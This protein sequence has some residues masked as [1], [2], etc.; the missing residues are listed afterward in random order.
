VAVVAASSRLESLAAAIAAERQHVIPADIDT[1]SHDSAGFIAKLNLGDPAGNDRNAVELY[2]YVDSI[3]ISQPRQLALEGILYEILLG[4]ALA[5]QPI[6][7]R[8]Y[9]VYPALIVFRVAQS[10]KFSQG[11]RR[12]S[13]QRLSIVNA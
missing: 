4:S 1:R 10:K 8:A 11:V 5:K 13:K 9:I 7:C 3:G 12:G 2:F 6:I